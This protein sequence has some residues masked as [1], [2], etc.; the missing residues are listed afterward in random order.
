[1]IQSLMEWIEEFTE[2]IITIIQENG[3]LLALLA[4]AS[5]VLFV[6]T[7][8]TIPL[9]VVSIPSNYFLHENSGSFGFGAR[10][11]F[12]RL[13]FLI[14]KNIAGIVCVMAGFV[15][16]FI[17]GQGLLTMF[18]GVVLLNFPG[19]RR[20]ELRLVRHPQIRRGVDWIRRRA[21]KDPLQ[22]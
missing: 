12:V 11:P 20:L 14:L 19:K 1:M 21:G 17:P 9:L 16:L 5:M 8:L 13:V 22:L 4:G 3:T 2:P 10:H 7:I 6:V 18:I 15:M